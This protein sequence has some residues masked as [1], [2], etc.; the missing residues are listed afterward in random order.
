MEQQN[1]RARSGSAEEG[2]FELFRFDGGKWGVL[3]VLRRGGL[4]WMGWKHG[5]K[6]AMRYKSG[7]RMFITK[8]NED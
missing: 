7:R 5:C 6:L 1:G 4:L 8:E 3:I 2:K